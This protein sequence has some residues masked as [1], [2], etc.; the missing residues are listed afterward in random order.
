MKIYKD[1]E[2][3]KPI[4]WFVEV[5]SLP[6]QFLL[7]C[8]WEIEKIRKYDKHTPTWNVSLPTLKKIKF[9]AMG[10][11]FVEKTILACLC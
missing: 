8:A 9:S 10:H 11:Y 7:P 3:N 6:H 1:E 2:L 4:D 5:V